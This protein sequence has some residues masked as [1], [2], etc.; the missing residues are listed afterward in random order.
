M[1]Y[2]MRKEKDKWCVV[3][4]TKEN[5]I[6]TMHCYSGSDA[7]KKALDYLRALYVHVEDAGKAKSFIVVT[8]EVSG[9]KESDRWMAVSS[10]VKVDNQKEVFTHEAMDWDI[11]RAKRTGTYPDLRLFHVRGFKVGKADAMMRIGDYAV[12]YGYWY[13]TP[14]AQAV[15]EV[16]YKDTE[17]VK[18]KISRGFYSL[19]ASGRCPKC[20]AGLKVEMANYIFGIA[21][22]GCNTLI[23]PKSFKD[24]ELRHLRTVTFDITITDVPAVSGTAIVPYTLANLHKKEI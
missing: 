19:S 23:S 24:M 21:C 4:G 9:D 1:P 15:K 3:K 8:K 6:E 13:D 11:A 14:F 16:L 17:H 2:F 7:H 18:N 22:K 10:I 12:D 20:D 5:P